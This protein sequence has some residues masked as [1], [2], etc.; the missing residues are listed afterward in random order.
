MIAKLTKKK[1]ALLTAAV[2]GALTLPAYAA[3]ANANADADTVKVKANDVVVTASRTEQMV[4]ETPSSVEVITRA[5]IDRMGAEN[6]VQAL[7]L[8]V[9]IDIHENGM[10]GNQSAIRGMDT[11]Q[12]LILID[13]RRIRTE[14][15]SETANYY[16]LQRVNMDDVDRIEIVRGAASSLYGA[17]ALGGVINI[18][19]KVPKEDKVGVLADWTSRQKDGGI[20]LETAKKGNWAFSSSFKTT[21]IRERGSDA[22]SNMY[23]NK[24]FFDLDGRM[25][26]AKNKWLDVFF[27]Y[28]KE[29]LDMKDSLVQATNYDH[30]RLST[31]VKFSG[32]DHLGNYDMQ[33]YYTYFNKDQETRYRHG[34]NLSSFDKMRFDSY[35]FDGKRSLALGDDH[36]LTVGGEYR[37]EDYESTRI[38]GSG[39][40]TRDG[41]TDHLG[42]SSMKYAALYL[43]DEW[44]VTPKWLLI[45][46]IRWDYNDTFGSEVTGKL[47]TTYKLSK[48]TRFKA[49]IGTAYRAPTASELFFSWQHTPNAIMEVHINGNPDLKPEKSVNFDLGFEAEKGKTSGK[50]TYFHNKVDDLIHIHT[51]MTPV[52]MPH[53]HMLANG[54]YENVDSA[55]MQ[56]VEAEVKHALG[57]GFSL[58]GTYT[59]LDAKDD[60]T[61][62]TTGARLTGRAR[63]TASLQ[64]GYEDPKHGLSALLWNDWTS[65]Y[66]YEESVGRRSVPRDASISLLNFVVNKKFGDRFSAYLGIDNILDKT[67][68]ALAYDGRIWR[69][70]VRMTF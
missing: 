61:G 20:R 37:Q 56:G 70:G 63:H 24:Y 57:A 68:D 18:I 38:K 11:N 33:L 28:M 3:E 12:T 46:S 36:L 67:S 50:V 60:T 5:D 29:D 1:T 27:D 65:G 40:M 35:V 21:D 6:L 7:R 43:Q 41:I 54:T 17:D 59:Y 4:K 31:G 34:G 51:V 16:E 26:L 62:D 15:T 19:K 53:F 23:G 58:R 45:P 66:R 10:V 14:N 25:D 22:M 64:L 9:G 49:N 2:L 13:G 69:G 30:D 39:T 48:N 32:R 42:D 55:T 8:A 44:T 47:G 52:P